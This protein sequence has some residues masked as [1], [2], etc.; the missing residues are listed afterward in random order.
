MKRTIRKMKTKIDE[1]YLDSQPNSRTDPLCDLGQ[2][3][4]VIIFAPI[5]EGVGLLR[6]FQVL[7]FYAFIF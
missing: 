3:T 6:T 2:V 1:R 5:N 4:S 7:R